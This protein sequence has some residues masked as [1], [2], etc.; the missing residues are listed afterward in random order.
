MGLGA[1]V[2]GDAGAEGRRFGGIEV[3][4]LFEDNDLEWALESEATESVAEHVRV[5]AVAG[6]SGTLRGL[7]P[8]ANRVEKERPEGVGSGAL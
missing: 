2:G 4:V 5:W 7:I 6:C 8:L 1:G 3:I